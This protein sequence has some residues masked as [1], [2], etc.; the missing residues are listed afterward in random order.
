M[1]SIHVPTLL[2]CCLVTAWRVAWATEFVG[3]ET[4]GGCHHAEFK[5][6]QGSH[7]ELAMQHANTNTVLGDFDD[8]R[9]SYAGVTS[10][11]YREGDLFMVYTDGPDGEMRS[12]TIT[13]TFGVYP[14]QQYLIGFPDGR[15]QALGIAWD[16]RPE[17]AGGQR[18][19]HVYE[20]QEITHESRLHW[21]RPSQNWNFMCADCHSTNLE[22]NYI[23]NS[24]QFSSS[25]SEISVGCEACH[26]PGSR[27]IEWAALAA[28]GRPADGDKGFSHLLNERQGVYWVPNPET[29]NASRSEPNAER[30]EIEVC[31]S[32]HSRR[33]IIKEGAA[34]EASFLDHYVPALLTEGLYHASGQIQDE[35]YVWGS[36]IQ[37]KMFAAGVTCSDCHEPHSQ[38]LLSPDDGVCLQCHQ[39]D[40][41]QVVDHHRHSPE[42]SGAR[43]AN[44]HMPES[45]YMVVDP[46]RDHSMRVPRP[47]ESLKF[48]TPNACNQ[49]HTDQ[50]TTWAAQHFTA[51]YPSPGDPYQ[52]W[53]EALTM[54][55]ENDPRA[56]G[57][58]SELVR[59]TAVPDIARATAILELGRFLS[60][61]TAP[62]LQVALRD[63][64]ALVRMAA[65]RVLDQLPVET[66]LP[67]SAHL[68]QDDVLAVRA[69]AAR[70]LA[71]ASRT[72]MNDAGKQLLDTSIIE[73]TATQ[74]L[75]ADR[76]ES[77]MNLGNLST[78]LNK[79]TEAEQ[80]YRQALKREP[81]FIPAWINIADLYRAQG[82]SSLALDTLQTANRQ[83]PD[84]AE[85]EH[86][87]GLALVRSGRADESLVALSRAVE[88]EKDNARFAY[89]YAVALNS[90]GQSEAALNTLETTHARHPNNRDTLFA[91]ATINKDLKRRDD[92]IKWA[93]E[94]TRRYPGD[95]SAR[96][97][98][99]SLLSAVAPEK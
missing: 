84:S 15:Y 37:S 40:R 6:W 24:D 94:L 3:S 69:E 74:R 89:V 96:N 21:S 70:V 99:E 78:A 17:A 63:E 46:R 45:I 65:M 71:S 64:A 1:T 53:T 81:D 8:A 4:C 23:E 26:G 14:L 41:Y 86:A 11:F 50:N 73:Y 31:A 68:L 42:S 29:G 59:D 28:P 16:S 75:N 58:L 30:R 85:L 39:P 80:F 19:M 12:F 36:F 67:V 79:A 54:A 97:L 2:L 43:C 76:A 82:M 34:R 9:F 13:H 20:G 90:M 47:D 93:Q 22:K 92:A 55:R 18:W 33:G 51:W 60:P 87:L 38:A 5:A 32:C 91:L 35:V 52:S 10:R 77:L 98:L 7:H 95:P 57:A 48:G 72:Q 83:I 27:H 25:Y 62:A 44:C 49:C 88:L 66:A 61:Q 56:A